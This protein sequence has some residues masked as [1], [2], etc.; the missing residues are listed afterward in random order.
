MNTMSTASDV[1]VCDAVEELMD[2]ALPAVNEELTLPAVNEEFTLPA[3]NDE[4]TL[5]ALNVEFTV[6]V[7]LPSAT[8]FA[9]VRPPALLR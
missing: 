8:A 4:F 5:P 1:W 3:V 9:P 7:E 2:E 6:V